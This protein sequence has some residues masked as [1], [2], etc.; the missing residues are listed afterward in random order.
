MC[1][2]D[3]NFVWTKTK[4]KPKPWL[5]SN[6]KNYGSDGHGKSAYNRQVCWDN[7][8]RMC[9]STVIFFSLER[10][11]LWWGKLV[12][13]RP[14]PVI[15]VCL[16]LTA[17][18]SLGFLNFRSVFFCI[19]SLL[20]RQRRCVCKTEKGLLGGSCLQNRERGGSPNSWKCG[21][22]AGWF[23]RCGASNF[24]WQSIG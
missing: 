1:V 12:T 17:L 14:Y 5:T 6:R 20:S 3:C 23:A 21:I 10:L 7:V 2:Q 22:Q 15:L 16:L 9:W 11:F 13:R 24:I 4:S 19:F 8:I 18:A